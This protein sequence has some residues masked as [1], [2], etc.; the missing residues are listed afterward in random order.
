MEQ[1]MLHIGKAAPEFSATAYQAWSEFKT[2]S[3]SG[4]RGTWVVLFFYPRDFTF[5]CTTELLAFA[6]EQSAFVAAGVQLLAV[7]T[8]S[9]WS[10]KA[11]F[12]RDLKDVMYPILADTSHAISRAY[13]VLVE[14]TG[15]AMRGTFIIDPEGKLRYVVVSDLTV[16]RSV[17]E[18]LR[19]LYALQSGGLCPAYW[20]KGDVNLKP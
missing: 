11:W 12:E 3:L 5:V 17:S 16:G 19:V 1:S 13:G 10:H 7:S 20:K 2:I 8:D 6:A 15:D 9:A 4:I 14:E 18:T